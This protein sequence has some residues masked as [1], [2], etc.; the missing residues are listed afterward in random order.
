MPLSE[1]FP[2]VRERDVELDDEMPVTGQV[3]RTADAIAP[4]DD[5]RK[6]ERGE[7]TL[8][9]GL[10]DAG[11]DRRTLRGVLAEGEGMEEAEPA[12]IGD[13]L[14]RRRSA[15]VLFVARALEHGGVAREEV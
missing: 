11:P 6:R 1:A 3:D 14:K 8:R 2:P 5:T 10:L 9:V 15:L 12:G 13:P 4:L 7:L